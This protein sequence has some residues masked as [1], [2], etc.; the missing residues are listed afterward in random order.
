MVNFQSALINEATCKRGST[1][2][3]Y[4]WNVGKPVGTIVNKNTKCIYIYIPITALAVISDNSVPTA[5][6]EIPEHK[7]F[8]TCI[9]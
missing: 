6:S 1:V 5:G 2:I 9:T 7:R 3:I 8:I 4:K